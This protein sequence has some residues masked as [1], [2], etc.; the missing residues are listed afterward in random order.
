MSAV[1]TLRLGC[2]MLN[3]VVRADSKGNPRPSIESEAFPDQ[4]DRRRMLFV[5]SGSLCAVWLV[6]LVVRF[7]MGGLTHILLGVALVLFFAG[8]AQGQPGGASGRVGAKRRVRP[9]V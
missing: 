7:S 5:L 8:V 6:G 1:P 2:N 4:R 9:G 3:L